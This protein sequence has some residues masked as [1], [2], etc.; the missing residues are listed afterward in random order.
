MSYV[1]IELPGLALASLLLMTS[2]L[3]SIGFRL[4]LERS[5]AVAAVRMVVQLALVGLILKFI[6]EVDA[7]V[8]T[9]LFALVMLAAAAYEVSSR[10]TIRIRGWQAHVVG[11]GPAFVAGLFATVFAT[12]TIIG[13]EP[14]YAP[15]FMLP[16]L[17]M[18]LGNAL[19]GVA[20]VLDTMTDGVTRERQVVET[21]LAL[22]EPRLEALS[23][24][25][26]RALKNG[27]MPILTAMAATGLVSLPG[28]MT[29]QILAGV[30]PV[31]AAKYQVMILFLIAGSTGLAVLIAGLGAVLLLTDDRHRL[32]L[33]RLAQTAAKA[34]ARQD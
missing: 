15:R 28:M 27:L 10:Q 18:M 2:G 3:I 12:T 4:G 31:Q 26:R 22:G 29:G 1:P 8:W 11:A 16:I 32:R 24:V 7:P 17:G 14:W 34:G 20:L 19:A 21:R 9:A 13:N 25:L 33:E 6:F 5:M 23:G 30:S